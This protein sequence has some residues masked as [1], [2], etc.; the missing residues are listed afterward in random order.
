MGTVPG[1]KRG[2][3]RKKMSSKKKDKMDLLDAQKQSATY[4]GFTRQSRRISL[5]PGNFSASASSPK[6]ITKLTADS[7]ELFRISQENAT[8]KE[9][10]KNKKSKKKKKNKYVKQRKR[11]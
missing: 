2:N 9:K 4:N 5:G 10:N 1:A 8:S 6:T 11:S 3:K 7:L